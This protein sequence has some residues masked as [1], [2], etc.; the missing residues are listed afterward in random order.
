M[1]AALMRE[2]T[3]P[4]LCLTSFCALALVAC[5]GGVGT[6]CFQN[7]E[8]D[9]G[10]ICCHVGSPFTQGTCQTEA[11]CDDIGGGTGGTSGAG[12]TGGGAGQGGESGAGGQGGEGGQAGAGGEGAGGEGGQAGSAGGAGQGGSGGQAGQGGT[13]GEGGN[14]GQGGAGGVCA[15]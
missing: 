11:V 3:F 15:G 8:C 7:D 12:G 5:T 4:W 1:L 2:F 9:S 14:A 13:A 10:L 6:T